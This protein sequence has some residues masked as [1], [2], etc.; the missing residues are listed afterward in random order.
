MIHHCY[1]IDEQV[2][3]GEERDS[4]HRQRN[5][6]SCEKSHLCH[7]GHFPWEMVPVNGS[8]VLGLSLTSGQTLGRE[9]MLTNS[10]CSARI[11]A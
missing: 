9:Q 7:Q 5:H 8:I 6:V 3:K 4:C 10:W 1:F 11:E 2:R